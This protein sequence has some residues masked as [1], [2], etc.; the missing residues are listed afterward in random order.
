MAALI[1]PAILDLNDV[2]KFRSYTF[3]PENTMLANTYLPL[4]VVSVYFLTISVLGELIPRKIKP[5][6]LNQI[7][8]IYNTLM[9]IASFSLFAALGTTLLNRLQT[10]GLFDLF[11]D[12]NRR[13]AQGIL[14]FLYTINL[15]FKYIELLD[16]L[17]LCL[18]GKNLIF[19]HVYHHSATLLLCHSQLISETCMQWVII[20]CNLT[21]HIFLYAYYAACD[22]G[23]KPPKKW[24]TLM[25]IVQF[26]IDVGACCL[27]VYW[28]FLYEIGSANGYACHGNWVGA[29]S[30]SAII[31]SYL[32]LFVQLYNQ[33]YS[34]KSR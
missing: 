28:R 6:G 21:V 11:C 20:I 10:D 30:G 15:S 1:P 27:A 4:V 24:L 33:L 12:P 31:V 9:S 32:L 18:R 13:N 26:V 23:F 5:L 22:F 2:S 8:G 7:S 14:P 34:K 17:L 29:L 16:T 25:Q 19:L 3:S